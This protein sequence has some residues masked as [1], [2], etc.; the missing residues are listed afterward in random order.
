MDAPVGESA[1]RDLPGVT[2]GPEPRGA[3]ALARLADR[4]AR[5]D[6]GQPGQWLGRFLVLRLLGLVY[7]MA[8]LTLVNQGPG[9]IGPNGLEPA[10]A[11]LD[12]A[13][14]ELGGRG[15]GFW[16]APSLF[17]LGASDGALRAAGWLG[18]ALSAFV[19]AGY[20]NAIVL[21][22]LCVLQISIT[23]VGQT[24]YA[25]GW[26]LQLVETGFLCIFLC[27]LLDPRPF[28]RRPPPAA[29]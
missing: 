10:G 28:P 6:P 3:R 21:A 12:E 26:E 7:L 14:A 13:A 24:F 20:A 23:N 4:F 15:A 25:F 17:W 8:F 9:L 22:L 5:D 11:M 1:G 18:V 29:V 16:A 19:L 2:A 27:P